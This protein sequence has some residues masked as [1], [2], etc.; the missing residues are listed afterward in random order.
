MSPDRRGDFA[1]IK[2]VWLLAAV[3]C[4]FSIFYVD[5]PIYP[6]LGLIV[7]VTNYTGWL[8]A[9]HIIESRDDPR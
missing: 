6:L 2:F 7:A 9:Q 4:G 3:V 5:L 8:L 1:V